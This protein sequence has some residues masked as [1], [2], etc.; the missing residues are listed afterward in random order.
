[1]YLKWQIFS[2][3]FIP[4]ISPFWIP[5]LSPVSNT[6]LSPFP[7]HFLSLFP[8]P[9]L[10]QFPIPFFIPVSDTLFLSPF[11]IPFL[12]PFYS[13]PFQGHFYPSPTAGMHSCTVPCPQRQNRTPLRLIRMYFSPLVVGHKSSSRLWSTFYP[14]TLANSILFIITNKGAC[15]VHTSETKQEEGVRSYHCNLLSL[16]H[17]HTKVLNGLRLYSSVLQRQVKAKEEGM[18]AGASAPEHSTI[19]L[20][21]N[22]IRQSP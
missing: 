18:L 8:I 15:N 14:L 20:E 10:S 7:I 12:S 4:K 6:L 2:L 22:I 1:M 11:P 5:F 21:L 16:W 13:C 17:R 9:F 19:A 3:F